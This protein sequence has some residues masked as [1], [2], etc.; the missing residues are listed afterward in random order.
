MAGDRKV[1]I[2]IL[3]TNNFLSNHRTLSRHYMRTFF[4]L[5]MGAPPVAA[6]AAAADDDN[7][8]AVR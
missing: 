2:E 7:E 4:L 8:K 5:M 6:G 3:A 1:M